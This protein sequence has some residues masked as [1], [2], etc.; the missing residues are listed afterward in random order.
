MMKK[1]ISWHPLNIMR[2]W[3]RKKC[4][5]AYNFRHSYIYCLQTI[6]I[7]YMT[8]FYK[9]VPYEKDMNGLVAWQSITKQRE[10]VQREMER[11]CDCVCMCVGVYLGRRYVLWLF[12]SKMLCF[13]PILT[14][15]LTPL[16]AFVLR[17]VCI[18]HCKLW[19]RNLC[20]NCHAP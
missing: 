19:M 4:N 9:N 7:K 2:V 12:A 20:I 6:S 13:S 3:W 14:S 11:Q 8:I 17:Y 15:C 10:E 16:V 1:C 5:Y 18:R